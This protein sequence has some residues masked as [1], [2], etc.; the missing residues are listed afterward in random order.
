MAGPTVAILLRRPLSKQQVDELEAWLRV[1]TLTTELNDMGG[2]PHWDL[3]IQGSALGL[4]G[5]GATHEGSFG[6]AIKQPLWDIVSEADKLFAVFGYHPQQELQFYAMRNSN[7]DHQITGYFAMLLAERYNAI[8]SM[9]DKV[10]SSN[11]ERVSVAGVHKHPPDAAHEHVEYG[12]GRCINLE[13]EDEDTGGTFELS[14]MDGAS[15]RNFL[16]DP[17][18]RMVK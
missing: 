15:M 16:E 12:S 13:F 7:I 6:L 3:L 9:G 14:Y 4:S 8:I 11:D 17:L 5:Y 1:N 2:G 10:T 18:F